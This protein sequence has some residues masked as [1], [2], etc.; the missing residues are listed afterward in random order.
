MASKWQII[1]PSRVIAFG[2]IAHI[3]GFVTMDDLCC[4]QVNVCFRCM[5]DVES[6]NHL[7]FRCSFTQVIWH[8]VLF[9]LEC[10]CPLSWSDSRTSK[11]RILQ[12]LSFM[13]NIKK[14]KSFL[15]GY[16]IWNIW[17]EKINGCFQGKS[18]DVAFVIARVKFC[19]ASWAYVL[20]AFK[21][22]LVATIEKC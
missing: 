7:F 12:H 14:K 9:W 11:G 13:V 5:A 10:S 1:T 4:Y 15:Y 19:V 20:D 21:V 8:E 18:L 2:W 6:V 22:I 16:I 17:K 3:L